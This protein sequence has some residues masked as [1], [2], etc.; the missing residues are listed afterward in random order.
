M[1]NEPKGCLFRD[2]F[3]ILQLELYYN[4]LSLPHIF[5]SIYNKT[6]EHVSNNVNN[7]KR[8]EYCGYGNFTRHV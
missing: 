4:S 1:C 8:G 6:N 3:Q 2:C 7:D 5:I